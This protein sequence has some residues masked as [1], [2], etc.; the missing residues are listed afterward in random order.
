MIDGFEWICSDHAIV[1]NNLYIITSEKVVK[2]DMATW[3][4]HYIFD[5]ENMDSTAWRRISRVNR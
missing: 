3:E 2:V 5:V 4:A 1:D